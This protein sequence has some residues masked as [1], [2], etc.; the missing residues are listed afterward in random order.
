M[1]ARD[2]DELRQVDSVRAFAKDR[3]LRT[4]LPAIFQET[5]NVYRLARPWRGRRRGG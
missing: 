3:A 4:L 1:L 5:T 2:D